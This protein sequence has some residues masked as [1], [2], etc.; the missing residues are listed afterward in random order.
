MDIE[1]LFVREVMRST[2]RRSRP[3][4]G[5]SAARSEITLLHRSS[6]CRHNFAHTSRLSSVPEAE[7]KKLL[8]VL[9]LA[10][11]T[12][13]CAT[14]GYPYQQLPPG[15]P[16]R[17]LYGPPPAPISYQPP[18]LP[19]G[20]WD[21][22]MMLASGTAVQ[23]LLMDGGVATG[24]VTA[25]DST[26]LSLRVASGDV[27]LA[28]GKIMRIDRLEGAG[29]AMKDGAKGAAFG[30]GVVGVIGL[31][32]GRVPPPR[33]FAAGGIIGAYKN[34]ELGA[35]ARRNAMIYLAPALA[36]GAQAAPQLGQR[37]VSR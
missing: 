5:C 33:L 31:I 8:A 34:V 36:S 24:R 13:G 35:M 16:G 30:A 25:A 29:S 14:A 15:Y 11:N 9:F 19:I 20:R 22:V 2:S 4:S 32:A 23:V 6:V 1:I 10:A 27:E 37:V 26:S 7:M 17:A 28:A 21:N 18:V 12:T 3:M